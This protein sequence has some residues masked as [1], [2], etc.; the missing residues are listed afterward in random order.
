MILLGESE[1]NYPCLV[2]AT[3]DIAGTKVNAGNVLKSLAKSLGGKG[4]GKPDSAQGA[5][6]HID[7]L[8]AA[9]EQVKSEL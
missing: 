8:H 1:K 5:V 3:K 9:I 7:G 6:P 2:T 4:G